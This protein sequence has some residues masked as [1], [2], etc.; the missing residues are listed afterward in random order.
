M[1]A[2]D[3][4]E[5]LLPLDGEL[6]TELELVEPG[7]TTT[8]EIAPQREGP[9]FE[10]WVVSS[11]EAGH[12]H[13][14]ETQTPK[15]CFLRYDGL[16]HPQENDLS[17]FLSG[18]DQRVPTIVY[19]HGNRVESHEAETLG[20]HVLA[21]LTS[22]RPDGG[23]YRFVLW[24]W[25]SGRCGRLVWDARVKAHRSDVHG[26]YLAWVIDQAPP[27][28]PVSL[29]GFSYGARLI[30]G[31]LHLL[32]G[33]SLDGRELPLH[34]KPEP[35]RL[36]ATFVAA[37]LDNHWLLPGKRHGRALGPIQ[38]LLVLKNR[39]DLVLKRY[40]W[41][42]PRHGS[43]ALGNTGLF[44]PWRVGPDLAKIDQVDV[45]RSVGAGHNE[46]R[47]LESHAFR[48]YAGTYVFF[49]D[50]QVS[51]AVESSDL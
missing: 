27:D 31:A 38:R 37:A 22:C 36:R 47:Y 49:D 12:K 10:F 42:D 6:P 15:L 5:G 30:S 46:R 23:N 16:A 21:V 8:T 13:P 9:Q 43:N 48:A 26:Y 7:L 18:F 20:R 25:P 17:G 3:S 32:G 33:G 50:W 19:V 34:D 44:A 14:A 28:V 11:R 45:S 24:S 39:R 29:I 51:P 41:L 2:D 35:V 1:P 4:I 40:R